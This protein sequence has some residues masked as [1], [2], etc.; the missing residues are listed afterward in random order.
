VSPDSM[1]T[2]FVPKMALDRD[3]YLTISRY[4]EEYRI[5]PMG[6]ELRKG[7]TLKYR[8]KG[9]KPNLYYWDGTGWHKVPVWVDEVNHIIWAEIDKLG[10]YRLSTQELAQGT[11]LPTQ[12]E[13]RRPFPNPM[14]DVTHIAVALPKASHVTLELYNIVGQ[15]IHTIL[16]GNMGAGYHLIT[17]DGK[18]TYG[19]RLTPGVYFMR[20]KAGLYE[21]V[22]KL[23]I[24]E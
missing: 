8:Y 18:D 3:R 20:I 24:L 2:L 15:K 22:H 5:G 19:N 12:Y 16:D 11:L 9:E 17:W 4:G 6:L 10:T 13:V 7:A 23:V 14:V 1:L 21:K